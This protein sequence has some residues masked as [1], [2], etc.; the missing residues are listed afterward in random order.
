[1]RK[2]TKLKVIKGTTIKI[3]DLKLNL[4]VREGL[5]QGHALHLAELLENKIQLEPIT[6]NQDNVVIDGRHRIEAHVLAKLDEINVEIVDITDETELIAAAYRANTGGAKP[7][8]A[9]D[10]E[11]TV[12]EL[13]ERNET[14][15]GIA[16]LLGLPPGMTRRYVS[17]VKSRLA[18]A[19]LQ[20]AAAAVTDGGRTVAQAAE[21]HGVDVDKLKEV[22][23]GRRR[24]HREGVKEIRRSMSHIYRSVSAKNAA[25]MRGLLEKFQDGDVNE[26]QVRDLFKHLKELQRQSS[27]SVLEWENRFEAAVK[28]KSP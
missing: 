21:Q 16:Q 24:K 3:A 2:D 25:R 18:R 1:M 7:P 12:R 17:E 28:D 20:R 8:T 15:K 5:D 14:I 22:L 26:K 11:H 19:K 10:T 9:E 13:V 27:R 6:V 23:S 4:F